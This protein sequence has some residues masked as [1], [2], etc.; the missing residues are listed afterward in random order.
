M[1]IF[2]Y[3][4]SR[5]QILTLIYSQLIFC[6]IAYNYIYKGALGL[7]QYSFF[8]WYPFPLCYA[9]PHFHLICPHFSISICILVMFLP[10]S[11][12][13]HLSAFFFPEC[14]PFNLLLCLLFFQLFWGY[15][16]PS[17]PALKS[18]LTTLSFADSGAWSWG[19][20]G[21]GVPP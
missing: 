5:D 21:T 1:D 17:Y 3:R 11:F 18:T 10:F 8:L 6:T 20:F 9:F 19:C 16:N 4:S 13:V 14:I 2:T 15:L 7:S 12:P